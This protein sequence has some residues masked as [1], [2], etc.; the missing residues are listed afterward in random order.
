MLK[1]RGVDLIKTQTLIPRDAYFAM[2]D[3]ATRLAG[4]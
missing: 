1:D 4:C 3:E 2:A